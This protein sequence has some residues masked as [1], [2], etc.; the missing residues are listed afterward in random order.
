[1]AA[2]GDGAAEPVEHTPLASVNGSLVKIGKLRFREKFREGTGDPE[3]QVCGAV[4]EHL[5]FPSIL[6]RVHVA[7]HCRC[8]DDDIRA[9][10]FFLQSVVDLYAKLAGMSTA[11]RKLF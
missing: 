7:R 5:L 10:K 9:G 3:M 2:S 8:V 6:R 1:M 11:S 4:L